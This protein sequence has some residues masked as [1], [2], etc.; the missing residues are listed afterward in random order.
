MSHSV[1]GRGVFLVCLPTHTFTV[2]L[3][4]SDFH[5]VPLCLLVVGHSRTALS[6][7]CNHRTVSEREAISCG[8]VVLERRYC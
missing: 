6:S 8:L 3:A 7:V 4:H 5:P 1:I 2:T